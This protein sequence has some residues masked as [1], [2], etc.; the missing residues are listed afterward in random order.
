MN[1][2]KPPYVARIAHFLFA[3]SHS[4]KMTDDRLA[5][6]LS[7][8]RFR[9]HNGVSVGTGLFILLYLPGLTIPSKMTIFLPDCL[10]D[11]GESGTFSEFPGR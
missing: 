6:P 1:L 9:S 10:D 4:Q 3:R 2:P 7:G 5:K 11:A 8:V